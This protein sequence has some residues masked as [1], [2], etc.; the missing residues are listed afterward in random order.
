MNHSK[1]GVRTH[2]SCEA[3][4][5]RLDNLLAIVGGTFVPEERHYPLPGAKHKQYEKCY[6]SGTFVL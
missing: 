5:L 4:V 3:P 2:F 6:E 1:N